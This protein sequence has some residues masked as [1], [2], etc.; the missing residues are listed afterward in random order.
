MKKI[1]PSLLVIIKNNEIN[2]HHFYSTGEKI[3][4]QEKS[5]KGLVGGHRRQDE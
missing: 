2:F 3:W 1:V 5:N 4:E